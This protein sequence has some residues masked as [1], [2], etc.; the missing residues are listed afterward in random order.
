MDWGMKVT[1]TINAFVVVIHLLAL[2]AL[3]KL[4]V[5]NLNGNQKYLLASLCITELT[6]GVNLILISSFSIIHTDHK[7]IITNILH[8]SFY[9]PSYLTYFSIMILITIDRLLEFRLNIKYSLHWFPKK[10]KVILVVVISIYMNIFICMAIIRF[11]KLVDDYYQKYLMNYVIP[12]FSGFFLVLASC[13]YYQIYKKI[14]ENRKTNDRIKHVCE[15]H[16]SYKQIGST[17]KKRFQ[18]FLP[19]LLIA[20]FILFSI[21]PNLLWVV[22]VL[23]FKGESEALK[24]IITISFPIGWLVDPVIYI[25]CLKRIRMRMKRAFIRFSYKDETQSSSLRLSNKNSSHSSLK[26]REKEFS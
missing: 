19:G 18:I 10:V 8:I 25:F 4:K 9:F 24:M 22:Y 3:F 20:T 21:V 6:L 14:K 13:T 1:F 7:N 2:T 5:N 26:R 23:C 16:N 17:Q 12:I 11:Y 15:V